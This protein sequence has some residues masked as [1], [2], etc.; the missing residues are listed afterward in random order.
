MHCVLYKPFQYFDC[1]FNSPS[2]T[3]KFEPVSRRSMCLF[4]VNCASSNFFQCS[5]LLKGLTPVFLKRRTEAASNRKPEQ[6]LGF[7]VADS[8]LPV[9]FACMQATSAFRLKIGDARYVPRTARLF[10]ESFTPSILFE[11]QRRGAASVLRKPH[12]NVATP[13]H[14]LLPTPLWDLEGGAKC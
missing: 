8:C 10:A 3:L 13:C 6:N 9:G 5:V 11:V 1:I 2:N 7:D 12:I 14:Q 4:T